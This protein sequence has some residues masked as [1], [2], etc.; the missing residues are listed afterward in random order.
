MTIFG[1]Q[2]RRKARQFHPRNA[3]VM[4]L[5]A[6]AVVVASAASSTK[7]A[8]APAAHEAA[9]PATEARAPEAWVPVQSLGYVVFDWS[10]ADG[11]VPGFGPLPTNGNSIGA[12]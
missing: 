7:P 12:Q 6:A 5:A 8:S 3:I 11:V 2:L 10:D 4:A 1:H 9:I